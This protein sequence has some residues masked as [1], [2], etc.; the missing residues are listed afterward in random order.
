MLRI[1]D[2]FP[3]SG[4]RRKTLSLFCSLDRAKLNRSLNQALSKG[5][6]RGSPSSNLKKEADPQACVF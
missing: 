1:L 5:F 3:F 6:N 4:E 2:L